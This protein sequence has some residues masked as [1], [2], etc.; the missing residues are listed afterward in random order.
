MPS[1]A[2]SSAASIGL[3]AAERHHD[4]ESV[5]RVVGDRIRRDQRDGIGSRHGAGK[6]AGECPM[7][8]D[9]RLGAI[10]LKLGVEAEEMRAQGGT[11]RAVGDLDRLD[12]L[13]RGRKLIPEI[14]CR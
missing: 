3:A 7:L 5:S 9:M 8:D 10:V 13:R 1:A 2:T 4:L 6:H 12:S 14:E 11:Q